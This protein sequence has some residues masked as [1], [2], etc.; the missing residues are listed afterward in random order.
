MTADGSF[1]TSPHGASIE[2]LTH[3]MTFPIAS[4]S[5]EREVPRQKLRFSTPNIGNGIPSLLLITNDHNQPVTMWQE[6]TQRCDY[7]EVEPLGVVL[8]AGH[9]RIIAIIH[10]VQLS[11]TCPSRLNKVCRESRKL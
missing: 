9:Q 1:N 11:P 8:E 4:G 6:T 3:R 5:R 10:L 7:T 2:L